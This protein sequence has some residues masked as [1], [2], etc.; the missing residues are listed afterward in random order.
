MIKISV[1]IPCYNVENY[2]GKCLDSVICNGMDE[3]EVIAVNDGSR[4][5]TIQVLKEYQ[6]KYPNLIII[7]QKNQGLS[8]ARNAGL[9]RATGEYIAFLDSD[10]WVENGMYQTM[11][12]KAKTEGF[13]IVACGVN[14]VY[15]DKTI[16]IDC[17]LAHDITAKR[18][19]KNIMNEWYTV[20]WNK[21][22]KKELIKNMM[23]KP[24]IWYEDVEFLYRLLP[25]IKSVGVVNQYYCNYI[26]REGSI[27]YTYNYKLYDLIDNFNGIIEYYKK[28]HEYKHYKNEL[29]Y[30]YVRYVY[31]TF[32]KRLAKTKNKQEFKKGLAYA[33]A[34]V[35]RNFPN[36]K[37]NPYLQ[38]KSGKNIYLKYFNTLFA[39]LIY[40]KEKNKMN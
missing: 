6:K 4:D 7:D 21:I 40:Y 28:H 3:I 10:D 24:N 36:Y 25:K 33:K 32:I 37:K 27:T 20:V 18:E 8:M 22:Y 13:D 19:L 35:R 5:G 39:M 26:Q 9:K 34:E 31:G 23:F 29:E 2:V 11:Y 16:K 12:E 1:I 17:G 30:G 15:P 38:K 14:V